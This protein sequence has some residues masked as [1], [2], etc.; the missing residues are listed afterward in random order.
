MR[1]TVTSIDIAPA[2]LS[3]LRSVLGL[4]VIDAKLTQIIGLE[5]QQMAQFD[6]LNT[7]IEDNNSAIAEI[8]TDLDD[9][10]TRIEEDIQTLQDDSAD[11]AAVSAAAGRI[12]SAT[13]QLRGTAD[14]V[15]AIDPIPPVAPS[16]GGGDQPTNPDA[17]A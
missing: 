1:V 8:G 15:K 3:T 2:E 16:D 9:A 6:E 10:V 7:A 11:Q 17:N 14:R 4:D 13:Q 12:A 5:I